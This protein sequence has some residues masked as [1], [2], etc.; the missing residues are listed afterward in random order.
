M[1]SHY[2]YSFD[3]QCYVTIPGR[4]HGYQTPALHVF[5]DD[6]CPGHPVG[7]SPEYVDIHPASLDVTV[8]FAVPH[9]G[10]IV[11]VPQES[12]AG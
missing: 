3:N 10:V 7:V 4:L 6:H 5:F 2:V 9:T 11:V 1:D 8:V 12:D